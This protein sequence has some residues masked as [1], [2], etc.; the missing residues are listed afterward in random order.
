[1]FKGGTQEI[2]K[3]K[4]ATNTMQFSAE[5]WLT[6][7]NKYV[8]SMLALSDEVWER[9]FNAALKYT[10]KSNIVMIP[11]S[12]EETNSAAKKDLIIDNY[13]RGDSEAEETDLIFNTDNESG[14]DA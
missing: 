9:I 13:S 8:Q 3:N 7:T 11:N 12:N 10:G 2:P 1:M 14:W 5:N 4:V 6:D